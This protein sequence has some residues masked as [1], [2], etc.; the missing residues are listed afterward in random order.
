MI[1]DMQLRG[2]TERTQEV[3]V[4]AVRQ[5]DQHDDKYPDQITEEELRQ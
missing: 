4:F 5:L 3:Y 2:L 1:G